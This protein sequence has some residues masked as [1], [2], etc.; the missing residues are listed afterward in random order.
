[1]PESF[2]MLP[3]GWVESPFKEKFGVPRQSGIIEAAA[4]LCFYPDYAHP[5]CFDGMHEFSHIWVSF[6]F[7]QSLQQGWKPQVRP[8][9]LGGNER[10]GVFATR[11]PFRPNHLG[12]SVCRLDSIEIQNNVVSLQVSGLDLVDGT[13]VLDIKP[14]IAY[15]D[16]LVDA[17]SGF[18]VDKPGPVITVEF[19]DKH[20]LDEIDDKLKRLIVDVISLDPRPAYK[21]DQAQGNYGVLLAGYNVN[22]V[23]LSPTLACVT[24]IELTQ[25]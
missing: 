7:H 16:S 5:R 18:A 6:V 8:P 21:R 1:M 9:R 3:V 23:M 4:R 10:R 22:W 17:V 14:Y 11:S 20:G 2:R 24:G 25:S 12:L 15:A 19:A 13:P